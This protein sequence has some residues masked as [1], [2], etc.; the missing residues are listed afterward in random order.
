MTIDLSTSLG[1]LRLKNPVM[2]A[3]SEA[4]ID[5]AGIRACLDAGAGAVVAKSVNEQPAAARQLNI[6]EYALIGD[7]GRT[8]PWSARQGRESLL[9]RSGLAQTRFDDWLAMLG[10]CS[11]HARTLDAHVF[12]SITIA[13]LE[14]AI[15]MARQMATVVSAVEI[16]V[17][18]PHARE[19][20]AVNQLNGPDLVARYTR[21][22][23]EQV[24]VP[25][26]VKLPAQC[27]S[28]LDL[29]IAAYD[30]G[31]DAVGLIGR[32][33]GFWPDLENGKPV[34]GSWGAVGHHAMLP[35]SLYW[36]SKTFA[37][38]APKSI[39]GTN[40]A[41]TGQ[42]VAR[43]ILS[44]ASA[45]EMATAVLLNGHQALALAIERLR[46]FLKSSG[47]ASVTEARGYAVQYARSYADIPQRDSPKKPW[48]ILD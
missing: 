2:A 12:G 27:D 3:S 37:L 6:A 26:I 25:L 13:D 39:V 9:C 46:D 33:N 20:K 47:Y 42:D 36:I 45:V 22:V 48:N 29:A 5:E 24:D 31:A 15:R 4:T 40:G 10:R 1:R 43:F 16:N 23:R 8:V 30:A 19:A 41:R 18:A 14:P 11:D 44:G 21:A 7:D 35:V 34:L 28:P 32:F 38:E 17:G